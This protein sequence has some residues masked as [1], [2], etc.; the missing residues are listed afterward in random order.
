MF[1]N[2]FLCLPNRSILPQRKTRYRE[3]LFLRS[4]FLTEARLPNVILNVI[5]DRSLIFSTVLSNIDV[6]PLTG[7]NNNPPLPFSTEFKFG[8]KRRRSPSQT[9][10]EGRRRIESK[11]AFGRLRIPSPTWVQ[12]S[13]CWRAAF[14]FDLL[15]PSNNE[16][17]IGVAL[18]D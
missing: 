8:N 1:Y 17:L 10:C 11:N 7:P 6:Y 15:H 13:E 3:C 9:K 18:I 12:S 4:N 2:E 16:L 14:T 5:F